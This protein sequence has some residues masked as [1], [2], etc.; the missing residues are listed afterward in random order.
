MQQECPPGTFR[1]TSGNHF[2]TPHQI[3]LLA[4]WQ[5]L[6]LKTDLKEVIFNSKLKGI[7]VLIW[8]LSLMLSFSFISTMVYHMQIKK[9]SVNLISV[10]D[11]EYFIKIPFLIYRCGSIVGLPPLYRRILLCWQWIDL[12]HRSLCGRLLLS[13][14]WD[15]LLRH[16]LKLCVPLQ[17]QVSW[18]VR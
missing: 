10:Q 9:K 6:C 11:C 18:G 8:N 1:N 7:G 3:I 5:I 12:P 2:L 4:F 13:R 15:H 14:Q 16:A 17:L